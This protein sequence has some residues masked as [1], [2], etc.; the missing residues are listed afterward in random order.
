MYGDLAV[1]LA[2]AFHNFLI[3][4]YIAKYLERNQPAETEKSAP[5]PSYLNDD[6]PF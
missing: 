3:A 1:Q 6:I 4:K 2:G 5:P